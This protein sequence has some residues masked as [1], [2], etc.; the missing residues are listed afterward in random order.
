MDEQL[1]IAMQYD[2][3]FDLTFLLPHE[4]VWSAGPNSGAVE[5]ET[6]EGII[7][8]DEGDWLIRTPSGRLIKRSELP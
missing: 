7:R 1:N 8:V 2:G 6:R 4:K 3:T 5:V